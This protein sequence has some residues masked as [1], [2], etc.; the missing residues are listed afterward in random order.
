MTNKKKKKGG[1]ISDMKIYEFARKKFRNVKKKKKK[2]KF[3]NPK[4]VLRF[5]KL[6]CRF[7]NQFYNAFA[8]RS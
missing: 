6:D 2:V 3:C 1:H 5:D 4:S 8:R 7:L